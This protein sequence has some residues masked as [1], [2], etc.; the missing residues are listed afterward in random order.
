MTHAQHDAI[1]SYRIRQS[2]LTNLFYETLARE[3]LCCEIDPEHWEDIT[4]MTY[5]LARYYRVASAT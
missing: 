1:I 2:I 3:A 5:T 4:K